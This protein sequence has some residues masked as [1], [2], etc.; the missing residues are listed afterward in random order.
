MICLTAG[1]IQG[2]YNSN[3]VSG[4]QSTCK[5]SLKCWNVTIAL[6][7]GQWFEWSQLFL[8]I[9]PLCWHFFL[10]LHRE[11]VGSILFLYITVACGFEVPRLYGFGSE[12]RLKGELR[13]YSI[14]FRLWSGMSPVTTQCTLA[15]RRGARMIFFFDKCVNCIIL[16]VCIICCL[17][18]ETFL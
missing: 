4:T 3:D 14:G 9:Y 6:S 7:C 18:T 1:Y 11:T 10:C 5:S 13:L 17:S 15:K 16:I 8:K 12:A 2:C